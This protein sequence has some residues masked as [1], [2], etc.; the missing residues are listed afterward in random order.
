M[1]LRAALVE[2]E[3]LAMERLKL[4][5]AD[6]PDVTIIHECRNGLEALRVLQ[7]EKI[8][9]VFLDIEMP[10]M[11]G[12]D[13]LRESGLQTFPAIIFLTAYDKYA[14]EAFTVAATDYLTK[15]IDRKR[16][17]EAVKRVRVRREASAALLVQDQFLSLLAKVEL[18]SGNGATYLQHFI[19]RDGITDLI[20]PVNDVGWIEANDYYSS[21]H[22]GRSVHLVRKSVSSLCKLLDP[23]VFIRVHRSAMVN[24]ACIKAIV[25]E[26]KE[27]GLLLLKDGGHVK[28]SKEG[29]ARLQSVLSPKEASIP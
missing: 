21:L 11:N 28:T 23:N 1:T 14:V 24:I 10:G 2:D 18:A 29:R 9:L 3:P 16:L 7:S 5:L 12:L 17:S 8:D 26:G 19:V 20:I 15:P 13:V 25:R 22:V 6:E 27:D 4:L